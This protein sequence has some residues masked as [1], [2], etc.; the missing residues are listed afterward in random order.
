MKVSAKFSARAA[1]LLGA[2]L[3]LAGCGEEKTPEPVNLTSRQTS[4][5]RASCQNCHNVP[6]TGAPQSHDLAAWIPRME[7][8]DDTLLDHILNGYKGMPPL[9]Q[10]IECSR[11][12]FLTLAHYMAAP[13]PTPTPKEVQDE[14]NNK[15]TGE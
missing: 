15:E 2:A 4:L 12:D 10:C 7:Q 13:A 3:L 6:E 9:G 1:I 8:G 11:K 14:D 5:Y